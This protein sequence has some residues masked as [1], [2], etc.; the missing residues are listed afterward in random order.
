MLGI[1]EIGSNNTKTH[2]Y[3]GNDLVYENTSTIEF[4]R[5]YNENNRIEEEDIELL[6][7][8]IDKALSYKPSNVFSRADFTIFDKSNMEYISDIV[9]F[10]LIFI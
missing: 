4:K 5:N 9:V 3:D 10:N 8:V 2:I 1:I 7:D 6:Y